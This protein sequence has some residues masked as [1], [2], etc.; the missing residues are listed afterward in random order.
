VGWWLVQAYC[1]A[2]F[3]CE[4]NCPGAPGQFGDT[5][6]FYCFYVIALAYEGNCPGAPGQFGDTEYFYCFYVIAL[7]YEG[8]CPSAPGQFGGLSIFAAI[9]HSAI[10]QSFRDNQN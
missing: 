9:A 4:G 6:Y 5:E 10:L 3:I 7:A 2:W 8:N 1:R